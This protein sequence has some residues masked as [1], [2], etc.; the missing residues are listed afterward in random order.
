MVEYARVGKRGLMVC[1]QRTDKHLAEPSPA[2]GREDLTK[3]EAALRGSLGP[4]AALSIPG[5]ELALEQK[6]FKNDGAGSL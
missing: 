4:E 6:I 1:C 2:V 5:L 3:I